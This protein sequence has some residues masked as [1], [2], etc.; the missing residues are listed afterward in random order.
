MIAHMKHGVSCRWILSYPAIQK[1]KNDKNLWE[2]ANLK[3]KNH[4]EF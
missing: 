1:N 2:M 4:A 3:N